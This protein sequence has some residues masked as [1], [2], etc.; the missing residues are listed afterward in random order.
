MTLLNTDYRKCLEASER[1][2]WNVTSVVPTEARMDFSR[3]FMPQAMFLAQQLDALSAHEKLKLNQ[4]FGRA[5]AYLFYF[6]EAY[7]VPATMSHAQAEMYGDEIALRALLR[8]TE[9]E[10]KHQQLFLRFGELFDR[11]FGSVCELTD[12][13]QE[14]ASYILSKSPMA[15]LLMTLHLEIITQAHFVD[16]MKDNSDL[17]PLFVSM[18]RH[19]WLEEAQ[20][21]KLDA[22][23]LEKI[24]KDATPEQIAQAESEYIELLGAVAGLLERQAVLDIKS[25]ERALGESLQDEVREQ[26]KHA[27]TRSYHRA[28]LWYG[29][30]N[31]QFLEYLSDRFPT[32]RAKATDLA[33]RFGKGGL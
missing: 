20:H 9:E 23:E 11:D 7:I 10:V 8:F 3:P 5:Y 14:V 29:L 16:A 32:L 15:V 12:S 2:S 26:A 21:A 28:F 1:V 6:V 31:A 18:F 25:L 22:L 13:P 17:E 30:T 19:H 33:E 27:Q 4:I 24:V